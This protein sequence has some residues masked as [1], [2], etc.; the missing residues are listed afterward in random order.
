MAGNDRTERLERDLDKAFAALEAGD[1]DE[2]FAGLERAKRIDRRNPHVIGLAAAL[3]DATGDVDEALKQYALLVEAN[4]DDAPPRLAIARLQLHD[5]GEPEEALATIE[6][7]LEFVDEESDLIDAVMLK[8]EALIITDNIEGAREVLGELA[9]TVIDDPAL[10]LD[11]AELTLSAEDAEGAKR[12]VSVAR[13][14]TTEAAA[15]AD[16]LHLLGRIHELADERDQMIQ[17]WQQVRV[18]DAA[19]AAGEVQISDD[20]LEKIALATLAELPERVREK[21]DKVPILIDTLP[22]EA[23]VADGLDPRLLGVFQGSPMADDLAPTVTNIVL[24][25]TNLERS[26][27]DEEHLADEVRITVLHETAHYFG[28]DEEDLEK[29]GLD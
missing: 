21:L 1:L 24:F 5:L 23:M 12:W 19:A 10:A 28:L 27:T 6:Q 8:A 14:A 4:P 20:E 13:K 26:A 9:S 18:L 16:A 3:A 29:L 25:K 15:E 7:A 11:L 17:C 22:S 2:A